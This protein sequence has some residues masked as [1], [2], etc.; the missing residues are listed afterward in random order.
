GAA[1]HSPSVLSSQEIASRLASIDTSVQKLNGLQPGSTVPSTVAQGIAAQNL[2]TA[3]G[4][5]LDAKFQ[6][7][8]QATLGS[9]WEAR[10]LTPNMLQRAGFDPRQPFA[11]DPT[12][13]N[14]AS[15]LRALDPR[16]ARWSRGVLATAQQIKGMCVLEDDVEPDSLVGLARQAQALF[17]LPS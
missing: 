3:L 13:L 16:L 4:P 9:Q 14:L 7:A 11:G 8:T 2:A 15:P 17:P 10:M 6:A 5:S 12:T 1:A